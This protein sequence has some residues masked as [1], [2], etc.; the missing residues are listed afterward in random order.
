[1]ILNIFNPNGMYVEKDMVIDVER[2]DIYYICVKHNGFKDVTGY[3]LVS[4]AYNKYYTALASI[5]DNWLKS[6][7]EFEDRYYDQMIL[8]ES[9]R[10]EVTTVVSDC[11][12]AL[13]EAHLYEGTF[14][15][16]LYNKLTDKYITSTT[17]VGYQSGAD[18]VKKHI[19]DKLSFDDLPDEQAS[20]SERMKLFVEFCKL[21]KA[22]GIIRKGIYFDI[23]LKGEE[24]AKMLL[25]LDQSKL[26]CKIEIYGAYQ[27]SD[28]KCVKFNPINKDTIESF[29]IYELKMSNYGDKRYVEPDLLDVLLYGVKV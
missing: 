5:F 4:Q 9:I 24:E 27:T 25:R 19:V 10:K 26:P 11:R 8:E 28:G 13:R 17:G 7:P 18:N 1:M 15:Y 14:E 12:L 21:Y 23:R 20:T 29:D 22:H 6:I 3:D 16:K 2:C